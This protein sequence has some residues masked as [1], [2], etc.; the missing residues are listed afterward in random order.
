[1]MSLPAR[2]SKEAKNCYT[3][4][5]EKEDFKPQEFLKDRIKGRH[6]EGKKT[7]KGQTK[8]FQN[9]SEA[10]LDTDFIGTMIII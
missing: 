3:S 7:P 4:R 9:F 2:R 1:M 5:T 8:E 6:T 10:F